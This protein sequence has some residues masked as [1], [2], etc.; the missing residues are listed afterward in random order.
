MTK[1]LA[2]RKSKE[3]RVGEKDPPITDRIITQDSKNKH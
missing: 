1:K 2:V 3:Q